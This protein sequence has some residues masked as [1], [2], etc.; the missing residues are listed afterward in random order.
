MNNAFNLRNLKST[1][2]IYRSRQ[3]K[4]NKDSRNYRKKRQKYNIKYQ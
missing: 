3:K 1:P 2:P 4:S